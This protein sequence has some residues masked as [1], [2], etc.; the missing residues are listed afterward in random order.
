M[1]RAIVHGDLKLFADDTNILYHSNSLN[2]VKEQAQKDLDLINDWFKVNKLVC[3]VKK[4]E[5]ILI[6]SQQRKVNDIQLTL[7]K[8]NLPRTASCKY[9][10]TYIDEHITW[11]E[12]VRH[13]CKK[14]SPII[15][16]IY[17]IRHFIPLNLMHQLYYS[18]IH[19]HISYCIEVWGSAY[20]THLYPLKNYRKEQYEL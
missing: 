3:N 20:D 10:G 15:G 13:V 5:F 14:I 11:K 17:K 8:Q 9:L 16:I 19:S 7:N 1:P 2:T 6:R 12:H 18:L 4:S